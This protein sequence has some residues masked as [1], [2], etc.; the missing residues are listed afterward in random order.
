MELY[1]RGGPQFSILF[2][3][4]DGFKQVNDSFGHEMGDKVLMEFSKLLRSSLR[5]TDVAIRWGGDEFLVI[6]PGTDEEEAA[7]YLGG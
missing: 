7:A 5:A 2:L 4:L 3:D 6:L 1:L